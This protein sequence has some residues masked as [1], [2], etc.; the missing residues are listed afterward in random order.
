MRIIF[1]RHGHPNY[2]KDCLTE[3]GHQH[4]AAAARRLAGE[5]IEKIYSSTCGR[6]L[7]TAGYTADLLGLPIE[8]CDY[9]REIG[10]GTL[11]GDPIYHDG[12]PWDNADR[13]VLENLPLMDMNAW[14]KEPLCRNKARKYVDRIAE[15]ADA[16]LKELGFERNGHYYRCLGETHRTVAVFG[17][18]GA[19]AAL[20]SH[21]FGLP[22]LFVCCAMGLDYTGITVVTLKN[23]PGQ[24]VIPRFEVYNDARHIH[25]LE[26]QNIYNR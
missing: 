18:G 24:L 7:E 14:E 21:L 25:G 4:A 10:W 13:M 6:A 16:L 26:I 3:L 20:F 11:E 22:F 9:L 17:H 12:H 1:V 8:K 23:D 2:E 19:S 5:G 15:N